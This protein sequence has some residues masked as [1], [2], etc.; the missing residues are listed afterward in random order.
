MATATLNVAVNSAA[1]A[2]GQVGNDVRSVTAWDASTGGN[3]L[4]GQDISTDPLPLALGDTYTLRAG[5][6]GF[7]QPAAANESEE[8]AKRKLK[9][10]IAGGVYIQYHSTP[11][12]QTNKGAANIIGLA[13]TEVTEAQFTIA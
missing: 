6:F 10:A 2:A 11:Y 4:T 9:G 8:M 1:A 7:R 13:R 3:F 12:A 5:A